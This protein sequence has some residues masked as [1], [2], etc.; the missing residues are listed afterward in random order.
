MPGTLKELSV[1]SRRKVGTTSSPHG[2][3]VQGGQSLLNL[4]MLYFQ[5][6]LIQTALTGLLLCIKS[7]VTVLKEYS[8]VTPMHPASEVNGSGS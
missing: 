4:T 7:R 3:Y 1:I 5:K 8:R 2:L 6:I